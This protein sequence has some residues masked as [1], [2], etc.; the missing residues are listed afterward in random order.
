MN[1]SN[2]FKLNQWEEIKVTSPFDNNEI[3]CDQK[4]DRFQFKAEN[5]ATY[6]YK[7][8]VFELLCLHKWK[9]KPWERIGNKMK[10]FREQSENFNADIDC[11]QIVKSI[12]ELQEL[13]Q[14][15]EEEME[16]NQQVI[17]AYQ[18]SRY[19]DSSVQIESNVNPQSLLCFH[20]SHEED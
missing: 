20:A 7:D 19:F 11:L 6:S 12:R 10:L 16:Q 9:Y 1:I 14:R 8:F 13:R 18:Q 4:S 3:N 15:I 2:S 17:E 5:T